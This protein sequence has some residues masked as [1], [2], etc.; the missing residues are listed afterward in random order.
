VSWWTWL[1]VGWAVVAT[2]LALWLGSAARCIKHAERLA[3]ERPSVDERN[4]HHRAS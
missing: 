3:A 2:V 4:E 1:L